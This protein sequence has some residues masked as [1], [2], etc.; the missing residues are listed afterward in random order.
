MWNGTI[1]ILMSQFTPIMMSSILNLNHLK[2][3]SNVA[4]ISSVLSIIFSSVVIVSLI[5]QSKVLW[6]VYKEKSTETDKIDEKFDA[7]IEGLKQNSS[8]H[9]FIIL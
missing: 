2:W 9:R 5:I 3:D 4:K 6:N 7:L 1:N 8:K